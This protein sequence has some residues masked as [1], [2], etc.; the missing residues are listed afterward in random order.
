MQLRAMI[1]ELGGKMKR[2]DRGD[3]AFC[4][5]PRVRA[6]SMMPNGT[7]SPITPCVNCDILSNICSKEWDVKNLALNDYVS[8]W[9]SHPG[10]PELVFHAAMDNDL[11]PL[12]P[13]HPHVRRTEV[14]VEE[15]APDRGTMRQWLESKGLD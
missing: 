15:E 12:G 4:N 1:A 14:P 10:E 9:R 8:S 2:S 11:W 6:V 5:R 7:K 13:P 3:C